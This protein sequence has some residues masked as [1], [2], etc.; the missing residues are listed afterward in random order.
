ME[1]SL[2]D[3]SKSEVVEKGTDYTIFKNSD[4]TR[5]M[6]TYWFNHALNSEMKNL[7]LDSN[8]KSGWVGVFR[9]SRKENKI[10][11]GSECY[12]REGTPEGVLSIRRKFFLYNFLE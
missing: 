8:W 4:G 9:S 3:L 5:S 10:D 11:T 1:S 6:D 2:T 12:L 7:L